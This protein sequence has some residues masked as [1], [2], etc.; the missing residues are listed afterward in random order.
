MNVQGDT[1]MGLSL[2]KSWVL[3]VFWNIDLTPGFLNGFPNTCHIDDMSISKVSS[4]PR[5]SLYALLGLATY[6]LIFFL[7]EKKYTLPQFVTT[8]NVCS[9]ISCNNVW[10]IMICFFLLQ[11]LLLDV[12][13][14]TL[15][16]PK[17]C[18]QQAFLSLPRIVTRFRKVLSQVWLV[19]IKMMQESLIVWQ[20][21]HTSLFIVLCRWNQSSHVEGP[22]IEL[23]DSWSLWAKKCFWRNWWGMNRKRYFFS[24]LCSYS[25]NPPTILSL[26]AA[27]S[28]KNCSCPGGG[29]V[30]YCMHRWK[31]RGERGW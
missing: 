13:R 3:R 30:S 1:D 6:F 28:W 21:T 12:L 20:K 18:S 16:M 14:P 17:V 23:G 24:P 27:R 8:N 9:R 7:T 10:E 26:L 15:S 25:W 5:W 2:W 29:I 4:V 22:G 31:V 11:R 19:L